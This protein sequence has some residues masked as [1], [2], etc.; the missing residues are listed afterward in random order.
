[1]TPKVWRRKRSG[2]PFG[3]YYTSHKGATVNLGTKDAGTALKRVRELVAG[4]WSPAARAAA[5]DEHAAE[6]AEAEEARAAAD[7]VDEALAG[8][9]EAGTN[10]GGVAGLPAPPVNASPGPETPAEP[11]PPPVSPPIT[12]EVLPPAQGAAGWERDAA[13]A[14]G[15][16]EGAA[17]SMPTG[18]PS[19]W[20]PEQWE[21]A[22]K[23]IVAAKLAFLKWH[24]KRKHNPNW[25]AP[26]V[27]PEA[28]AA[29]V[30]AWTQLLQYAGIDVLLPP[31]LVEM[32]EKLVA[33]GLTVIVCT[34]ALADAFK[35]DALAQKAAA[36]AKAQAAGV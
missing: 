11:P 31:W 6:I 13:D 35:A 27:A 16:A 36:E 20:T 32:L 14:A 29:L 24:T 25:I 30:G 2:R 34:T 23:G 3:S 7:A 9:G 26:E 4:R 28:R 22:A 1:M 21:M 19:T 17:P 33:P 10:A 15:A 18:D 8:P 12:P 5:D